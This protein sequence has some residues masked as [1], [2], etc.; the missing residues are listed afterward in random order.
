[1]KAFDNLAYEAKHE[2]PQG[3]QWNKYPETEPTEEGNYL[4]MDTEGTVVVW[5]WICK[6]K[7]QWGEI[8]YW[9]EIN[10]PNQ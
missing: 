6:L 4:V 9:A 7:D 2:K 10:P 5:T 1:M 8:T 3:I